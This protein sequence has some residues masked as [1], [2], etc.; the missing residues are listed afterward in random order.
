M[1]REFHIVPLQDGVATFPADSVN[2]LPETADRT[3]AKLHW[4]RETV[5]A[6][7][8]RAFLIAWIGLVRQL[9]AAIDELI[10]IIRELALRDRDQPP[11]RPAANRGA[12][13]GEAVSLQSLLAELFMLLRKLIELT[14][15]QCRTGSHD[16]PAF[17][18]A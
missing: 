1:V 17:E 11:V 6:R 14:N 15:A 10:S 4:I 18:I 16:D 13:G 5:D 8:M 3:G 9:V 2:A 12:R 7:D